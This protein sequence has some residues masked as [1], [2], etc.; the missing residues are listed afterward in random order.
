MDLQNMEKQGLDNILSQEAP[1]IVDVLF[2]RNVEKVVDA[3]TLI[4]EVKKRVTISVKTGFLYE[5]GAEDSEEFLRNH[6]LEG[7]NLVVLYIDLVGST[8]IILKLPKEKFSK[9]ITTL[10][11][12]MAYVIKRHE[13]FVLKFV[14]DAVI[15][16]FIDH[17]SK[18]SAD[19]AVSCAESMI[20]VMKLGINPI[21]KK[22]GL[23]EL[24][25]KIG[26]NYGEATVVLYGND[27][28]NSHVD[29]IGPALNIGAKIQNLASPDQILI[30]DDAYT[31]LHD[32]LKQYFVKLP[33]DKQTW[34]YKQ[35]G[36]KK[37]Y[38]VYAYIG[39]RN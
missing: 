32:S 19:R 14:G 1:N 17:N 29:L 11:Q 36:S 35:L 22:S 21:L 34:K 30:G 23:P 31:R 10:A 2:G 12:E 15:G 8:S 39:K 37:I 5:G 6:I 20:K 18:P 33:V 16:Y 27:V 38:P 26:M 3:D 24:K 7:I 13:G 9:V 25:I 4:S 28:K